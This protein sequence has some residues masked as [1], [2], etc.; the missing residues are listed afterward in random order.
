MI[1]LIFLPLGKA[2]RA[3]LDLN[4]NESEAR[5]TL[6]RTADTGIS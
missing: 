4:A 3:Y 5:S 1:D 6:T 2:A